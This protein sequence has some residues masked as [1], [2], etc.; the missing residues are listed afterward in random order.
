MSQGEAKNRLTRPW[1]V[2]SVMCGGHGIRIK[3]AARNDLGYR[4]TMTSLRQIEQFGQD[5]WPVKKPL[6]HMCY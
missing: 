3:R 2:D 6:F 4:A 5:N 1:M